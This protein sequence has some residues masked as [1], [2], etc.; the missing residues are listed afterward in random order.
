M[1]DRFQSTVANRSLFVRLLMAVLLVTIAAHLVLISFTLR[2]NLTDLERN[3]EHRTQDIGAIIEQV[4]VQGGT[5]TPANF[6]AEINSALQ[7]LLYIDHIRVTDSQG[8]VRYQSDT[9]TPPSFAPQWFINWLDLEGTE[10]TIDLTTQNSMQINFKVSASPYY[11]ALWRSVTRLLVLLTSAACVVFAVAWWVLRRTLKPLHQLDDAAQSI[12]QGDLT[13]RLPSVG[14]HSDLRPTFSAFNNMAEETERLVTT[15][16]QRQSTITTLFKDAPV[17]IVRMNLDDDR[18]SVNPAMMRYAGIDQEQVS[19]EALVNNFHPE[20]RAKLPK[21]WRRYLAEHAHTHFVHRQLDKQGEYRWVQTSII[22]INADD[23]GGREFVAFLT[24]ITKELTHKQN[25]ERSASFY[26]T[27]SDIN[28]AIVNSANREELFRVVGEIFVQAG[29][30]CISSF[31]MPD[32]E[33]GYYRSTLMYLSSA[34]SNTVEEL[35]TRFH[36][37]EHLAGSLSAKAITTGKPLVDNDF[38]VVFHGSDALDQ[39]TISQIRAAMVVPIRCYGENVAALCVASPERDY[40]SADIQ[41]YVEKIGANISHALDNFARQNALQTTLTL[42]E[43]SE[44]QLTTTLR[45]I[46]DAIFVTDAVGRI[47]M[48]NSAAESMTG[49]SE[50]AAQGL[51]ASDVVHWLDVEESSAPG[52]SSIVDEV[53][54]R[55]TQVSH[56]EQEYLLNQDGVKLP[57]AQTGAPLRYGIGDQVDG[58]VLVVRDQ[59]KDVQ[60]REALRKGESRNATLIETLP[61]GVFIFE[62][63]TKQFFING[64]LRRILKLWKRQVTIHDVENLVHP[65]DIHALRHYFQLA[66]ER[67]ETVITDYYRYRCEDGSIIWA[68]MRLTPTLDESGRVLSMVG[69]VLDVTAEREHL[70]KI[71][72]LSTM[73]ATLSRV[74]YLVV[75]ATEQSPLLHDVAETISKVPGFD[76]VGFY[77][78]DNGQINQRLKFGALGADFDGRESSPM[79]LSLTKSIE[80]TLRF[81]AQEIDQKS[82]VVNDCL[83]DS[84]FSEGIKDYCLSRDINAAL[85]LPIKQSGQ[86]FGS[87]LILSKQ[88]DI[89]T[90]QVQELVEEISGVVSFALT[91]LHND[92]KK[93]QAELELTRNEERLRLGLSVT[94]T[95]MFEINFVTGKVILDDV[96]R[97]LS[98]LTQSEAECSINT[99]YRA[100]PQ[101]LKDAIE[102]AALGVSNNHRAKDTFSLDARIYQGDESSRWLRMYGAITA[103]R[104]P[105]DEPVRLL[106]F[107]SD[108]THLKEQED[109]EYLA[110]TVFDKSNE[111]ILIL[112]ENRKVIMANQAFCDAYGYE[113]DEVIDQTSNIFRSDQHNDAFYRD[114]HSSI[115]QTGSWHGEWWRKRKGGQEYPALAVISAVCDSSG[116]ITHQVIQEM[117]ISDQKE[118]EQRISNLA[119]H[120]ELTNLP[121][122]SLLRDRVEQA[123]AV[124]EREEETMALLFLDLDHFKN[125]ND[126]LGHA[127]GDLL[128]QEVAN[129]LQRSIRKS[130]TV[131]RLGGDEFLMLLPDADADDAAHV[132]QK[133]LE[134]CI[135]PYELDNHNLAVTPSIGIAMFPRDG[136]DY[137]ELL[138]KADTAMYRAKDEGRNGYRFFT[139]EMNQAVF[140]R[141]VLESRLRKAV[142]KQEFELHYQ[143]KYSI[144]GQQLVG[145]EALIRWHQPEMGMVSPAQFIPV[146]EDS[147][148][149]VEIGHWVLHEACRQIN[150]WRSQSLPSIKVSIN[151]S[152]RQFKSRGVEQSV[153]DALEQHNLPGECLEIEITESL[154]AQ[155]MDN[156]LKSL[157]TLKQRGID[158]SV[159]DFGTGYSSLSYLKRFPI[160]R[161]KIDQSFVRDLESESDDRAIASAVITMG[162][163][164]GMKVI[165]EGVETEE[166]LGILQAMDC[167]E[168]QGYY[169]GR[170]MDADAMTGVMQRYQAAL[171]SRCVALK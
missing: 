14:A 163:S 152:T 35:F 10:G 18:V 166:Q 164:L 124:S 7:R 138:K 95:G 1:L 28:S 74:N 99:F 101:E 68:K 140:Q 137:N 130:D 139:P 158:I 83:S 115:K 55:G 161:L 20:D 132:A 40:F 22:K 77:S 118:A 150:E 135:K 75:T 90:Q 98:G 21:D 170:P 106:G 59:S 72:T 92:E 102:S 134:E 41:E 149:I 60:V 121:N 162:H 144:D 19:A 44:Q 103:E 73:Y 111:S 117:D 116:T 147:G 88:P 141:M 78:F 91:Q 105:L 169:L 27:L 54:T 100:L 5:G 171:A 63:E 79:D 56:H 126:S 65:D 133:V 24:D 168:V 66:A 159:D 43:Q 136:S 69:G 113:L 122:R 61:I 38:K 145:A 154:L 13:V 32:D 156:T 94:H 112:G 85:A 87:I 50:E 143:P 12:A 42:A 2:I 160:D 9:P 23:H 108:I 46:G 64:E 80:S 104:T 17:G 30:F 36:S 15:L 39:T 151:F 76:Q 81:S 4:V 165:A 31:A 6:S 47:T 57:I 120:D 67:A 125:I 11:D 93:R 86:D 89:F 45:S 123:I 114:I 110:A 84:R 131:G 146:A 52:K 119:Y 8:V 82:G 129:R 62:A 148:L 49:F 16:H 53:I 157:K 51:L 97:G 107:I 109:K 96:S 71:Q 29:G 48:M 26:Q 33:P 34:E 127:V 25:S 3:L 70:H 142:E 153:F 58:V 167:D 155:D 128:L 37:D